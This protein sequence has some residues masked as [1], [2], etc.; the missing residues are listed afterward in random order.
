MGTTASESFPPRDSKK[1]GYPEPPLGAYVK[2]TVRAHSRS[3]SASSWP[4]FLYL[5]NKLWWE[6]NIWCLRRYGNVTIKEMEIRKVKHVLTLRMWL[7]RDL[8]LSCKMWWNH[9]SSLLSLTESE[10]P[11]KKEI[12][13]KP[14]LRM[15]LL[16]NWIWCIRKHHLRRRRCFWI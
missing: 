15:V 1:A 14:D 12:K 13:E 8:V 11:Q 3:G 5:L 2:T 9:W 7:H 16:N 10:E 4:V 6:Q